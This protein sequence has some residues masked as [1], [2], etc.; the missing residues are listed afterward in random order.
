MPIE[1]QKTQ[2]K[3]QNRVFPPF[4]EKYKTEGKHGDTRKIIRNLTFVA[5]QQTLFLRSDTEWEFECRKKAELEELQE[6]ENI[7]SLS[8]FDQDFFND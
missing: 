2:Q 3:T 6:L 7:R 5:R 8:K 1:K 4:K